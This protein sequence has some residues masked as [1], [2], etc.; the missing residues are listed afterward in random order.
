[1]VNQNGFF[2]KHGH[3][4]RVPSNMTDK[5]MQRL[6]GLRVGAARA[7]GLIPRPG[8]PNCRVVV[9]GMWQQFVAQRT[10]VNGLGRLG[11]GAV[12]AVGAITFWDTISQI[13][14]GTAHAAQPPTNLGLR[15]SNI[16]YYELN[17]C[18]SYLYEAHYRFSSDGQEY[19]SVEHVYLVT[20]PDENGK[21]RSTNYS[22][23]REA[24][25]QQLKGGGTTQE[26][27]ND[28]QRIQMMWIMSPDFDITQPLY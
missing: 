23:L 17:G 12:R 1:M 13:M 28:L 6:H 15:I 21:A 3:S 9:R 25:D 16:G 10:T 5:I 14:T 2:N 8:E 24:A 7:V 4:A 22:R 27:L 20:P 11:A 26:V 19:D 18:K